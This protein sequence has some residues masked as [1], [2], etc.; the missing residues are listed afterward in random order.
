MG[1]ENEKLKSLKSD[2]KKPCLVEEIRFHLVSNW[3]SLRYFGE[4]HHDIIIDQIQSMEWRDERL[5]C[6][7]S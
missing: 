6:E 7:F 4:N 1:D 3:E 2:W 5:D